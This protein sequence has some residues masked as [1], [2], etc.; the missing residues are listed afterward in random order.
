M[1]SC[2]RCALRGGERARAIN[3][4]GDT[5]GWSDE[6]AAIEGGKGV[7]G[8]R[9]EGRRPSSIVAR[10]RYLRVVGNLFLAR[11]G[12]LKN[13]HSTIQYSKNFVSS[14]DVS[15]VLADSI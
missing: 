9:G 5:E 14:F 8:G 6:A 3:R 4:P 1:A 11:G 7:I 15:P 2:R 12:N 10:R 13:I